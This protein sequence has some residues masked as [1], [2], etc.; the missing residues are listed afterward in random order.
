[1]S[2]RTTTTCWPTRE[3][4]D[5]PGASGAFSEGS[6]SRNTGEP[7]RGLGRPLAEFLHRH[8]ELVSPLDARLAAA[9]ERRGRVGRAPVL[10]SKGD[11]RVPQERPCRVKVRT[12]RLKLDEDRA[13]VHPRHST[14]GCKPVLRIGEQLEGVCDVCH[15]GSLTVRR[16][17][18]TVSAAYASCA[19]G[20]PGGRCRAAGRTVASHVS[21]AVPPVTGKPATTPLKG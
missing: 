9:P 21:E 11:Q 1:M 7:N 12:V 4:R 16:S 6:R 2:S 8:P 3:A 18:A 20:I 15:G 13:C 5:P 14:F 10:P 19:R 17:C